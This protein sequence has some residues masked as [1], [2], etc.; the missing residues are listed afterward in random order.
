MYDPRI[1][2]PHIQQA[3]ALFDTA[4][5]F[6][7]AIG[8]SPNFVSQMLKNGRPIPADLCPVIERVTRERAAQKGAAP[9]LCEQLRPDVAW[10]VLREHA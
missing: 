6:A 8:R 1:V 2:N 5:A 10:G 4:A 3:I 7:R 9:V